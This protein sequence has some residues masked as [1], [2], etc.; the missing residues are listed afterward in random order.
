MGGITLLLVNRPFMSRMRDA[1]KRSSESLGSPR[2]LRSECQ[3]GKEPLFRAVTTKERD[4]VREMKEKE[5]ERR[6]LLSCVGLPVSFEMLIQFKHGVPLERGCP[7]LS[8][9]PPCCVNGLEG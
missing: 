3:E 8:F 2:S 4:V 1:C 7:V 6:A 9:V 5:R